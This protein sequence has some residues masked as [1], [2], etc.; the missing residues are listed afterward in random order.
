MSF[1]VLLLL[2]KI[3]LT[4]LFAAGP[5]MLLSKDRL[6][7]LAG[8]GENSLTLYRLYGI[9]LLSILVIYS[10]GVDVAL[11][12]AFPL[13]AV[14]MGFVSNA[15]ATLVL[16]GRGELDKRPWLVAFCGAIAAG[17]VVAFFAPAFALRPL[18]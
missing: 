1:L 10:F 11:S 13:Y 15:G 18:W 12:G 4:L 16:M 17:L 6:D 9:A 8:L 14:A 7:R 3:V 5:L 2:L